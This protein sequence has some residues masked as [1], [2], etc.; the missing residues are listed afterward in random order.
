MNE[1]ATIGKITVTNGYATGFD[2]GIYIG[3]G[4]KGKVTSPL[5]NPFRVDVHGREACLAKYKEWLDL[6]LKD[7]D[8]PQSVLLEQLTNMLMM[9]MDITLVCFCA[10]KRCHGDIIKEIVEKRLHGKH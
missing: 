9:G 3:R 4:G 10:P 6:K 1:P 5:A 2:K 8:T 7:R